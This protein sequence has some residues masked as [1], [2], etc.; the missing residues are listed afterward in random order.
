MEVHKHLGCGFLE[1]VYQAALMLEFAKRGVPFR[2]E[3]KLP[4][5]YKEVRLSTPYKVDFI[6][7][8]KIVVEL[9]ALGRLSGTEEAQVINYLKASGQQIGLLMN[10]ALWSIAASFSPSLISL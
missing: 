3:V 6:C 8:D 2:R 1:P 7:F 5:F 9:K 10:L 4:V